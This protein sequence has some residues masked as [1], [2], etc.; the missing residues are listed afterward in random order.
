MA[1][2]K[3]PWFSIN[4]ELSQTQTIIATLLAIILPF[5][6]WSVM[7]YT[8]VWK[9]GFIITDKGD[10]YFSVDSYVKAKDFFAQKEKLESEDK[11]GP[12]GVKANP[13]YFPAPHKVFKAFYTGFTTEP[14]RRGEPWLHESIMNSIRVIFWGF[15]LSCLFGIPLGIMCGT[16]PI[17][18]KVIEPQ[19]DFIRYMPAPAFGA[20]AVTILGIAD[21]PK[22]AIIFIGTFFQMVLVISNTTRKL[23]PA[24]MEAAQTL[25]A[26]PPKL[27]K[28]VVVPGILP[29]LYNDLRILLGWAWTYLIVAELIGSMSGISEFIYRMQRYRQF[30]NVYAA[31]M[32]I[33]IIGLTTDQFLGWLGKH[34]FPWEGEYTNL[35]RWITESAIK[36]RRL[37]QEV[38]YGS[39]FDKI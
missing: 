10:S 11:K 30:E 29:S 13:V 34:L 31:I 17:F 2:P 35:R 14:R 24:L 39:D 27:I 21:S 32:M 3:K 36:I 6:A 33:G 26:T 12:A 25:G 20:L 4:Q 28:H 7:S 8:N 9:P 18:A 19:V 5:A 1:K 15:T 37:G 22:I 38:R 16:F 23:D